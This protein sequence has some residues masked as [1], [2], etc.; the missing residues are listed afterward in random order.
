MSYSTQLDLP[1][2]ERLKEEGIATVSQNNEH[3][4]QQASLVLARLM[5]ERLE[6]TTD[7]LRTAVD[8]AGIGQPAHPNCWGAVFSSAARRGEIERIGYRTS[9]LPSAHARVVAVWQK[10]EPN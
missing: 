8:R 7:D 4:K 2:G 6:V 9:H 10:R 5:N 3:W 1:T